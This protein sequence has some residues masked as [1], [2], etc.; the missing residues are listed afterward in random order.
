MEQGARGAVGGMAAYEEAFRHFHVS[1]DRNPRRYHVLKHCSLLTCIDHDTFAAAADGLDFRFGELGRAVEAYPG[2]AGWYEVNELVRKGAWAAWWL[3]GQNSGVRGEPPRDMARLASRLACRLADADGG[4]ALAQRLRLLVIAGRHDEAC[5]E[6]DKLYPVFENLPDVGVCHRLA[7]AI[8]PDDLRPFAPEFLH[9]RLSWRRDEAERR[10]EAGRGLYEFLEQTR[11]YVARQEVEGILESAVRAPAPDAPLPEGTAL[12]PGPP[13]VIHM[14]AHGGMGKSTQLA[15]LVAKYGSRQNPPVLSAVVD[16]QTLVPELLLDRPEL[17]LVKVA[18]RLVERARIQLPGAERLGPMTRFVHEH[19]DH[20]HRLDREFGMPGEP[21]RDL[22][23]TASVPGALVTQFTDAL[24]VL[25]QGPV[26]LCLDTMDEVLTRPDEELERLIRLIRRLVRAVPSL[27]VVLSGRS[28]ITTTPGFRSA[29][30]DVP[31]RSVELKPFTVEE[32]HAY[33]RM[34]GT[35]PERAKRIV[36]TSAQDVEGS[37]AFTPLVLA[38]LADLPDDLPD[39]L[40]GGG[41]SLYLF[42]VERELSNIEDT[43]VSRALEYCAVARHPTFDYFEKVLVPLLSQDPNIG[44]DG[45]VE[46]R[47]LWGRLIEHARRSAW[48]KGDESRLL[49]HVNV[50]RALSQRMRLDEEQVW[51]RFHRDGA[52]SCHE[53][54][55][56][57]QGSAEAAGWIAEQVYH[58]LHSAVDRPGDRDAFLDEVAAT[59]YSQVA[60]AWRRGAFTTVIDLADR[61]ISADFE[62]AGPEAEGRGEPD[63]RVMPPQLWYDIALERAY[64]QLHAVLYGSLPTWN[65][66]DRYLTLA[67]RRAAMTVPGRPPVRED[68]LRMRILEAA[69]RLHEGARRGLGTVREAQ[70][71]LREVLDTAAR[72]TFSDALRDIW[73]ADTGLLLAGC[74]VRISRTRA[75]AHLGHAE[76]DRV[77]TEMFDAAVLRGG[78]QALLVARYAM[79]DWQRADRPDLVRAWRRRYGTVANR[80]EDWVALAGADAELRSGLPVS[81]GLPDH[82]GFGRGSL[83]ADLLQARSHLLMGDAGAAQQLL[84]EVTLP[85]VSGQ[86]APELAF[87]TLMVLARA[88]AQTLDLQQAEI[89]ADRALSRASGDEE[90]LSVLAFRASTA[91]AVAGDLGRAH[92]W[93]SRATPLR[94]SPRG[95]AGTAMNAAECVLLHRQRSRED[96]ATLLRGWAEQLTRRRE[97]TGLHGPPPT[98]AEWVAHAVH[99]LVCG[100]PEETR[101]HVAALT[102]ALESVPEPGRRLMLLAD[103]VR[104]YGPVADAPLLT[105]RARIDAVE[106]LLARH[107]TERDED[108]RAAGLRA[109]WSA[110][111]R[112]RLIG[113]SSAAKAALRTAIERLG[114]DNG[115]V[116]AAWLRLHRLVPADLAAVFPEPEPHASQQMLPLR[117]ADLLARTHG[118]PRR[119]ALKSAREAAGLL[120]PLD[121][122]APEGNPPTAWHLIAARHGAEVGM[123]AELLAES[124]N[125]PLWEEARRRNLQF[126]LYRLGRYE[127]TPL[128][129]GKA[130]DSWRKAWA[131]FERE[132]GGGVPSRLWQAVREAAEERPVRQ[133]EVDVQGFPGG[134]SRHG[135]PRPP[136][137][138]SEPGGPV[139]FPAT[140]DFL[141][142]PDESDVAGQQAV[143]VVLLHGEMRPY[144]QGAALRLPGSARSILPEDVDRA[145]RRLCDRRRQA[146]PLLVLDALPQEIGEG[147]EP[148]LR[149][150]FAFQ[151]YLLGYVPTVLVYGPVSA[152]PDGSW[153]RGALSQAIGFGRTAHQVAER[154]QRFATNRGQEGSAVPRIRLLSH[155]P[156]EEM[157]GLGLL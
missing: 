29:F 76:A 152:D 126:A 40:P 46:P 78:P 97:D 153:R 116:H 119:Q 19:R 26:L 93:I 148:H 71:L 87:E 150:L 42:V 118:R 142:A 60:E 132:T 110:E 55:R 134:A 68:R 43:R 105:E 24:N 111:L 1:W 149:D 75:P 127:G 64:G 38:L 123:P 85:A 147:G 92:Q 135:R 155:I 69:L 89:C 59:W 35:A 141:L 129:S 36:E 109:L 90:R 37:P 6:F 57:A 18:E 70:G 140:E 62:N 144:G 156:A 74:E 77:F 13:L 145:V 79:R 94:E 108:T 154:L 22:R 3:D 65:E 91:L 54:A 112:Y 106:R 23:E 104:L 96:A 73:L 115:Q 84:E 44:A 107:R 82:E 83:T 14:H 56:R 7:E 103:Q 66:V 101:D 25:A 88:H 125:T 98:P 11:H 114:R 63:S 99:A 81:G 122:F 52:A 33:L 31:W 120:G 51:H 9:P 27:R 10:L 131:E 151:L 39:D 28:D 21:P 136:S 130:D 157:F 48:I 41:D 102:T 100:P 137:P 49:V 12:P 138:A 30:D 143:D 8:A 4:T 58:Q 50:R 72:A 61:L 124:L 113:P 67:R 34:R 2:E 5:E 121:P 17:L 139:V 117:A 32:A 16:A 47:I 146:P 128:P 45:P 15:W 86:V 95:E 20:L 133:V 53:L 80:T